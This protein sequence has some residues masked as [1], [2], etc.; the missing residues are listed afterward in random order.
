MIVRTLASL[1]LVAAGL[2]TCL[3]QDGVKDLFNGKDLSG[4]KGNTEL[5]SVQDGAITGRTTDDKPLKFNTFLIWE[6]EV[7][8][9]ELDLDYRIQG[10]N[11][12][13]QY[14]SKVLNEK[15]FVVGG[16]Q[17]DI[18]ATLK[19][20]GINY[21]EKGRGILANRGKRVTI[22]AD[23]SK[24]EETFAQDD[25]LKKV[26]KSDDWNHYRVV[27]KGNKLSHSINGTL[28]SET[29]DNQ[30]EKAATKGVLALQIHVGPPMVVQFKNLRLKQ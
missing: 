9:F 22:A 28:M 2:S 4:W 12:G 25:D 6:G 1:C 19:Y 21:E 5:W 18:D 17:A 10:G 26:I 30:K 27:A 23:G 15:D 29:I 7:G 3:A 20:A 24:Q 14:R 11:S 16:Y 8:D 13:I